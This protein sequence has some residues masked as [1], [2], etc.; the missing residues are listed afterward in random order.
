MFG[1][2]KKTQ[3]KTDKPDLSARVA[4]LE[5]ENRALWDRMVDL[6]KERMAHDGTIDCPGCASEA[7]RL[8]DD[9]DIDSFVPGGSL[10]NFIKEIIIEELT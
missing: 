7:Q 1:P 6:E 8:F 4:H 10:R 2:F 5:R 3:K 9:I